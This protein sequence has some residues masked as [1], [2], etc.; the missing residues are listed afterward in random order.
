MIFLVGCKGNLGRRYAAIMDYY[1]IDWVGIDKGD[2]IPKQRPESIII[3]TPTELHYDH[4]MSFRDYKVPILCEKPI[5][6]MPE[7]LEVLLKADID[8]Y[9]VD[10]YSY[11][12]GKRALLADSTYYS[13]FKSGMD[14]LEWD[15]LN[16]IGKANKKPI[17][18]NSSPIWKCTINGRD[19]N[20]ADMDRA[21]MLMIADWAS[22]KYHVGKDYIERAHSRVWEGYYVKGD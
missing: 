13:Y 4:I 9:M 12:T 16:I 14:G 8:L 21:Y 18:S 5:T 3:A 2:M 6:K 11:L 17:L 10:Q 19:L 20:I 1:R 7:K 22:G 15:C